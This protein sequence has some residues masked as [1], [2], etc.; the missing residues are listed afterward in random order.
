MRWFVS[1]GLHSK[2]C[3]SCVFSTGRI[4]VVRALHPKPEEA[5]A[6]EIDLET[7]AWTSR[8]NH[9]TCSAF[10]DV[11]S[12][13]GYDQD[14]EVA[15]AQEQTQALRLGEEL[16]RGFAGQSHR[17]ESKAENE[18]SQGANLTTRTD[19]VGRGISN[20][21]RHAPHFL[22]QYLGCGIQGSGHREIDP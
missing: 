10:I 2:L 21:L 15:Y 16:Q 1:A 12:R 17:E 20:G 7:L 3:A 22:G 11:P 13:A 19:T 14:Q 5:L 18:C 8:T 6:N 4:R 9:V